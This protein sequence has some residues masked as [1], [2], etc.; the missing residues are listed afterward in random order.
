LKSRGKSSF[1]I[2][3]LRNLGIEGL[4]FKRFERLGQGKSELTAKL[5][6]Q[7]T[8]RTF[9]GQKTPRTF[10]GQK[11]PRTFPGQKAPRTSARVQ[12]NE[13]SLQGNRK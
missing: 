4:R 12:R 9:P 5:P 2:E 7:K 13:N 8:P 10:P 6:G 11:A 3:G 1:A